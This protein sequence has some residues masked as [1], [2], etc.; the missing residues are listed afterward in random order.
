[1]NI[2]DLR[3]EVFETI[4][5]IFDLLLKQHIKI[6]EDPEDDKLEDIGEQ[7]EIG[8]YYGTFSWRLARDGQCLTINA[9]DNGN[10]SICIEE[11]LHRSI[12]IN[13]IYNDNEDAFLNIVKKAIT[14]LTHTFLEGNWHILAD[15]LSPAASDDSDWRKLLEL[16]KEYEKAHPYMC[17]N[18]TYM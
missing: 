7:L 8:K 18:I 17:G 11:Q 2:E 4:W 15:Y 16:Y 9:Y 1:M 12:S 10:V 6:N 14:D 5:S 13:I 3:H